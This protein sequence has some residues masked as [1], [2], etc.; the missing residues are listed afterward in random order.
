M[1]GRGK[2]Q[3]EGTDYCWYVYRGERE[4]GVN[5]KGECNKGRGVFT[6]CFQCEFYPERGSFIRDK[7]VT[8]APRN[9]PLGANNVLRSKRE[10]SNKRERWQE[11]KKGKGEYKKREVGRVRESIYF[12]KGRGI[13]IIFFIEYSF[14]QERR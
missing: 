11:D 8:E 14:N 7:G 13:Y 5:K 9:Q 3:K 2:S 10:M 4:I 1:E 6:Y 12:R